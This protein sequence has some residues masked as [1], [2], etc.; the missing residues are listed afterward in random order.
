M[1]KK[2]IAIAFANHRPETLPLAENLML[3]YEAIILEEPPSSELDQMLSGELSVEDYVQTI[4][5]EYPEFSRRMALLL[6]KMTAQGKQVVAEEPFLSQL[7]G[8]HEFFAEGGTPSDIPQ[9]TERFR[10]YES[11][12]DATGA[13]LKFYR[14]A[15]SASFEKTLSAVKQF[16]RMDARRFVLR[17]V[18]RADALALE[19]PR[20]RSVYVEAGQMHYYLWYYLRRLLRKKLDSEIHVK[21]CFLMAP[22]VRD[23][24]PG[25][26]L[27]GPGDVLTLRYMFHPNHRSPDEDL[28]AARAL[29]YSKLIEKNE[30]TTIPGSYPH[31]RNELETGAIVRRLS[32]ADCRRLFLRMRPM[33]TE[34]ARE[35][36]KDYL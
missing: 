19:A 22:V 1:I 4:D 10:V 27:Y 14:A 25:N 30:M 3:R 24:S 35:L 16:A 33:K 12:R 2:T 7:I 29:I 5:T 6:R 21:P 32:M 20:F 15:T 36:I 9:N 17:D 13:L 11:E 28:L 23:L 31:T 8:I 34:R 18:M 26:H